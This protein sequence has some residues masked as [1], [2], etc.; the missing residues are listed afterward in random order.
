MSTGPTGVLPDERVSCSPVETLA[1]M[2]DD[3]RY[4]A[5]VESDGLRLIELQTGAQLF[6]LA[7]PAIRALAFSPKGTYLLTWEKFVD[8]EGDNLRLWR[9]VD[10]V[11]ITGFAQKVLGEKWQWPALRWS[12]DESIYARAV[13]NEIHFFDGTAPSQSVV[14]RLRAERVSHFALAPAGSPPLVATFVPE[15][16]GQPATVRLWKYPDFGE[17]RFLA[18][19]TFFKAS[20]AQLKF[21]PDGQSLLIRTHVDVDTGGK[22]YDG[23]SGLFYMNAKGESSMVRLPKEGPIHD[24]QWSPVSTEFCA[25]FGFSPPRAALFSAEKGNKIIHDFGESARNTCRWAPHGRSFILAGFGNLGGELSFW[26]RKTLRCLK[27]VDAHMTVAHEWSPDSRHFLTAILWPRLRVDNGYK[28]WSPSG[29]LLH[30]EKKEELSIAAWRPA[31]PASF[32]PPGDECFH[33]N[34]SAATTAAPAAPKKYVPPGARGASVG[35]ATSGGTSLAAL[36]AAVEGGGSAAMRTGPVLGAEPEEG[37]SSR[38]AA[39]NKAKR[40]AAKK[41]KEAEAAGALAPAI[42]LSAAKAESA[43]AASSSE[44]TADKLLKK[45]RNVEKKLRQIAELKELQ[46]G[47]KPLEK[48][49]LDKVANEEAVRKELEVLQLAHKKAEEKEQAAAKE[50]MWR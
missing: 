37:S 19:K 45:V 16:K 8:G 49:Q 12:A 41:K 46:T 15:F 30:A 18:T 23:A 14:H 35:V 20:E 13:S 34:A 47:G 32:P 38:N 28:L 7:R 10:G 43:S 29:E 48:N 26:D 42:V 6:S 33:V 39:K 31:D 1:R 3:G 24:V 9:C 40:E 27:T 50:G 11:Y 21:S 25:L 36:A 4:L 17:G 44:E 22:S 2:S 5:V